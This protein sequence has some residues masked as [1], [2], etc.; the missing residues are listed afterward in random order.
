MTN[1]DKE[2]IEEWGKAFAA[3]VVAFVLLL[4]M[5]AMCG[6]KTKY[7]PMHEYHTE[8][9]RSDTA[10]FNAILRAFRES[11]RNYQRSSDSLTHML[12]ETTTLTENGDTAR[13]DRIEYIYL[14]SYKEKEYERIIEEQND[15]IEKLNTRL[16]SVKADS[17]PV[18]YP[19]EKQLTKWKKA[20]MDFGGIAFGGMI[21]AVIV[22]AILAWMARKRRK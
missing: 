9:I 17:I 13:H 1:F 12:K 14:S 21:V 7:V 16:E 5:C 19:V 22:I 11:V 2:I 8:T 10:V 20:K 18:P 6:C 4:L 15:S 3:A